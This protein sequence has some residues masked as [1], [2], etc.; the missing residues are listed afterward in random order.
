MPTQT[1]SV[2]FHPLST[3]GNL[4]APPERFTY[5]FYYEPH[6]LAKLAASDLQDHLAGEK[7]WD[8]DFGLNPG[9]NSGQGKMFGVLVVSNEAGDLG[10]LAAFSGKLA[11][12]NHLPGFVPPV[13]DLLPEDGHYKNGE[14]EIS[15][16]NDEIKRLEARPEFFRQQE[17][18]ARLQSAS[19]TELQAERAKLKATKKDR[20]RRREAGRSELDPSAFTE[21]E[22]SL[23][24]ESI[25]G[26]LAYKDLARAWQA[27]LERETKALEKMTG[28]IDQLKQKRKEASNALQ[29]WIFSQ[30]RFLDSTGAVKDLPD[31]F[32]DTVFKKPIAGAGECA[33]P[34]LLQFAY[35]NDYRPLALAEFWWGRAPDSEI[36]RHLNY[37]PAC[38]GKCQPILGHMLNGLEVDPN[39]LLVNPAIGKRIDIV[40][41]DEDLIVVN[42]P[43]EFL[44]V[45]GRHI[46]DSVYQ[47]ILDRYPEATGPLIVHRLDMSTSGLLLVA[48]NKVA[49]EKIQR[50][51]LKRTVKK[52]YVALLDGRLERGEGAIDLPLR[53][54]LE[55]RP[56]QIVD[57]RYGKSARTN[58]KRLEERPDG[59]TLVHF[60]PITGR[61]HQLRVHAAHPA[62]LNTPI[63]GDDLYGHRAERLCLHAEWIA[64]RH[65]VSRKEMEFLVNVDF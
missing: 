64:F 4:P 44:S 58:W 32:A 62:G 8:F 33:A 1:S 51:F 23:A 21:L 30:Y 25:G 61:T 15:A 41:E 20:K 57:A 19:A 39:P 49:H 56:R 28:K 26:Q 55:N 42:K 40:F 35:A 47:R 3:E 65:P 2:F 11:E 16:I 10:Y 34:K 43:A 9:A 14:R 5:P 22:Q 38:R 45:P 54:D 27:R 31:I 48:K 18:V 52:R 29:H 37:Y 13:F 6:P 60:W 12:S 17:L 50:Q 63:V 46:E 36:R 53:G 24:K 7:S 59:R